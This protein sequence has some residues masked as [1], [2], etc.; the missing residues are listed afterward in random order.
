MTFRFDGLTSIFPTNL[1]GEISQFVDAKLVMF[2][3]H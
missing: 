2:A 1:S 3:S